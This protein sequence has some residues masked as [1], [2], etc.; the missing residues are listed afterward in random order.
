MTKHLAPVTPVKTIKLPGLMYATQIIQPGAELA[1]L[2]FSMACDTPAEFVTS[3]DLTPLLIIVWI[4]VGACGDH[5][6]IRFI[7]LASYDI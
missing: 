2:T 3:V 7:Y 5:Q 1:E 4:K 6:H